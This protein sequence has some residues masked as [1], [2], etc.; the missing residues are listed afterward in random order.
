MNFPTTFF[1]WVFFLV[2][3]YGPD[4]I[5]GLGVTLQLATLGTILGCLI[6]F[7]VG[8]IRSVKIDRHS[9]VI[10]QTVLRVLKAF[11]AVYVEVIRGTPMM[12]QATVIYYGSMAIWG[13]DIPSFSAGILTLTI[14]IGAY[15]SESVRGAIGGIDPGQMEGGQA[16]G[17]SYLQIMLHVIIPQAFRNLIPQIGNTFVSAIKDTSVLN[18]IAVTELY[19]TAR[20]VTG[21][22]YKFFETYCIV[23]A[24]YFICTFT[25]SRILKLVEKHLAGS[26]NY[27]LI[28]EE[29]VN[30]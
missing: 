9:S 29:E 3:K 4:F 21:T 22:Y 28:A 25:I 23:C 12:V 27:E 10:S 5:R 1:G 18:V 15:F 11:I 20:T 17:M 16:I 24:I 2:E 7:A 13:L 8:I 6:G 26:S 19:F 30:E 14:H